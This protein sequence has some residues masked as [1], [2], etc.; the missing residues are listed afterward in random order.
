MQSLSLCVFGQSCS[1]GLNA[2]VPNCHAEVQPPCVM[3]SCPSHIEPQLDHCIQQI[4][5]PPV[6]P[7]AAWAAGTH[8]DFMPNTS[9]AT[10]I[11]QAGYRAGF[12][13][14][15][16]YG[17]RGA[18]IRSC[19][20]FVSSG[21]STGWQGGYELQT[22]LVS[23]TGSNVQGARCAGTAKTLC[24]VFYCHNAE[25]NNN[26]YINRGTIENAQLSTYNHAEHAENTQCANSIN[27]YSAR[28]Y[29]SQNALS[30]AGGK[31]ANGLL[32][33]SV[34]LPHAFELDLGSHQPIIQASNLQPVTIT[35]GGFLGANGT[36]VGGMHQLIEPGQMVTA[37][38]FVALEQVATTGQQTLVVTGCG[39]AISGLITL[40]GGQAAGQNILSSI[41]IPTRV[42]LNTI[43]FTDSN[44]LSVTGAMQVHGSLFALQQT[45]NVTSA[46]Q[47][48][49]LV[50]GGRGLISD[51]LSNHNFFNNIF[52]SNGLTLG[53]LGN[54]TNQG[55]ISASSGTLSI[56]SG[57]TIANVSVV[58]TTP[59]VISAPTV[60]LYTGSGSV[61][62]SGQI[63]ASTDNVQFNAP[64][65]Q[66][67]NINNHNGTI[68]A[69][70]AIN[71][72]NADYTGKTNI[73]LSGGDWLSKQVN[74]N[75]GC[76]IATANI[77][78]VTG[79]IN[80]N[81]GEAHISAATENLIIGNTNLSGDPNYFNTA[82]SVTIAGNLNFSGQALAIVASNNIVT[83][84]GA[85][86][87]DTSSASDN[88]G[89]ITM[90][91]GASF[92]SSGA[93][94][95][96]NDTTTTLTIS[97]GNTT[98]GYIDLNGSVSGSNVAIT[99]LTS[100]STHNGD[101][102]GNITL[103]AFNGSGSNA[104]TI[105][106][107]TAVTINSSGKG[108]GENGNVTM[109][110]G[111]ASGTAITTGSITSDAGNNNSGH[112][113]LAVATPTVSS[114]G[115]TILNGTIISGSVTVGTI[116]AGAIAL[117]SITA[118]N[119]S[120]TSITTGG[121]ITINGAV[122]AGKTGTLIINASGATSS[123]FNG[124]GS[125][126]TIT[127]EAISLL[128]GGGSALTLI[129]NGYGSPITITGMGANNFTLISSNTSTA[130]HSLTISTGSNITIGSAGN[131]TLGVDSPGSGLISL[132]ATGTSTISA[133][134]ATTIRADTIVLSQG[135]GN[136]L[137]LTQNGTA[138]PITVAGMGANN[139][140]LVSSNTSTA[141]TSLTIS[142]GS[143]ITIGSAGNTTL[144]VNSPAS[145]LI[146]LTATGTSTILAGIT[147]TIRA[148]TIVLSQGG[149]ASVITLSQGSVGGATTVAGFGANNF[150]LQGANTTTAPSSLTIKT[151][152]G[153]AI[154]SS[155]SVG[156]S[157][158]MSLTTTG[159]TSITNNAISN[160]QYTLTT[161]TLTLAQG[162]ANIVTF[163]GTT[164]PAIQML[165]GAFTMGYSTN[166][167][168]TVS[169]V[170]NIAMSSGNYINVP[171]LNLTSTSNSI[172]TSGSAI[173]VRNGA[174]GTVTLTAN[175]SATN[176]NVYIQSANGTTG[177]ISLSGASSAG[178]SGTFSISGSSGG[179]T[180]GGTAS[181]STNATGAS[182]GNISLTAAAVELLLMVPVKPPPPVTLIA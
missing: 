88:G 26:P 62:N 108:A 17:S 150:T 66:N 111:A 132:T 174:A 128:Q 161:G 2:N 16:G 103:V 52:S 115:M 65:T 18:C 138:N 92:T 116:Q 175:A 76:G 69:A 81:A 113:T 122:N 24:P 106:A 63:I 44:P 153:I 170:G 141:P 123:I 139:F 133:G 163:S 164:T 68:Q 79:P 42:V 71:V 49:S 134:I 45:A 37:A 6:V 22:A 112:V 84:T 155:V 152:N 13:P 77:G 80:T 38:Q 168:L 178:S 21:N 14:R 12:G 43:G 64:N 82:G 167:S 107:P 179:I 105:T 1:S 146:S 158:T 100:A 93:S 110:A 169:T 75:A 160:L 125:T 15:I 83:A 58:A 27:C 72:R 90:I 29:G 145:G 5:T 143:N 53:V 74:L 3:P 124:A 151:G 97:G 23:S 109:I 73:I 131:V 135:G 89:A 59:A 39:T 35:I 51:S 148:N 40:I 117:Q 165:V 182:A 50:V 7:P 159:S 104:G 176:Q 41:Q 144:G 86:T 4:C 149:G 120:T 94:S 25:N 96:T 130:P 157:G 67:I 156:A 126:Q 46:L 181:V 177:N 8:S 121:N 137:T 140:T 162:A 57:G 136:A 11:D 32:L 119:S 171:T 166:A 28:N 19:D 95:G 34:N 98:G 114:N 129:Q 78:N 36:I 87:I 118:A 102:G 54:V 173:L 9:S 56:N 48:G 47:L 70:Q 20:E 61:T 172:G 30:L 60:N 31:S 147:T 99:S 91:A 142:T 127:A 10:L 33:G 85:G 55:T 180:L 101:D 154:N